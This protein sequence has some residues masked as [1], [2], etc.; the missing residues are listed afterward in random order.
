MDDNKQI[1]LIREGHGEVFEDLLIKYQKQ[2]HFLAFRY[3]KDW[4]EADDITQRA[5]IKLYKF[6]IKSKDE[7]IVSPWLRKVIVNLCL[8]QQKSRKWRM[9]FRNAIR[10]GNPGMDDEKSI[11]PFDTIKDNR[12]SPEDALLNEELRSGMDRLV[13]KLPAQQKTIFFM[14]HFEGLKIKEIA[15]QLKI[16]EG[17]IKSQ[18][19]RAVRNLRK[20]LGEFYEA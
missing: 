17:Q 16:S 12:L 19:F 8:D 13:D 7:I 15:Q 10:S 9:F 20:G 5:F 11:D 1:K 6:I 14:K 3:L 4:D 2:A 18:L